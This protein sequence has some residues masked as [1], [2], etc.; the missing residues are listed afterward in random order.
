MT[1]LDQINE[2]ERGAKYLLQ[3]CTAAKNAITSL[4]AMEEVP[5]YAAASALTI[6]KNN[7]RRTTAFLI[8]AAQ[9]LTKELNKLP[10][11]AAATIGEQAP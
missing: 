8:T 2:L 10:D 9:D 1:F 7:V 4:A 5:Q 3:Q 6:A 11:S